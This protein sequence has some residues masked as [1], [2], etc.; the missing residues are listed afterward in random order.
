M[1]NK[2]K[3]IWTSSFVLFSGGLSVLL[4]AL[5]YFL[6]DV[7]EL[8]KGIKWMVILGSNAIFGYVAWHLFKKS[9]MYVGKVF[10]EGLEPYIGAWYSSLSY[11]C[12]FIVI[13]LIMRYMYK[14]KIFI[15]I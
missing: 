13:Y 8:R 3:K 12:G 5:F 14:N 1:G 4:L 15:K 9:F 6:I 2:I 10:I 11:L 7:L